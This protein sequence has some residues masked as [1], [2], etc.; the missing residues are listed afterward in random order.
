[1]R[2]GEPIAFAGPWDAWKDPLSDAWLQSFTI[3]TIMPNQLAADVRI[4]QREGRR[5]VPDT[6]T[7]CCKTLLAAGHI[8]LRVILQVPRPRAR[9]QTGL[10]PYQRGRPAVLPDLGDAA[11]ESGRIS[12]NMEA[13]G[14]RD[15]RHH[16]NLADSALSSRNDNRDHRGR[17]PNHPSPLIRRGS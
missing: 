8:N 7:L 13:A 15:P 16:H 5:V 6:R 10:V 17:T 3:I 4:G 9:A 2:G 11:T 1:M 12:T 14:C